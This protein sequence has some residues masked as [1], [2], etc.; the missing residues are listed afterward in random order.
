MLANFFGKSKPVNF[1][2][3]IVLF[4]VYNF[5]DVFVIN[6]SSFELKS[7]VNNLILF[8]G[9]L[10]M[11]FLYVFIITK[12]KLTFD[13]T[14]SFLLIVIGVGCLPI[15]KTN[16]FVVGEYIVLLLLFRRIYS[17]RTQKSIYQKLFDSGLWLGILFLLSPINIL[18]VVLIYC[19]ISL[20]T[21]PTVRTVFIPVLGFVSPLILFFTYHFVNDTAE[22]FYRIFDINVDIS[23]TFYNLLTYKLQLGV[24]GILTLISVLLKSSDIFSVSNTFKKSWGLLI[25][26]FFIAVFYILLIENKSGFELFSLLIPS[27][28]IIANWVQ[29]VKKKFLIDVVLIVLLILPFLIKLIV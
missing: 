11:F 3:I 17:L 25:I 23:Y 14:Y 15:F 5:L 26:H 8:P 29:S 24:F 22:V 9:F 13:N 1:V 12:N 20:Y 27:T 7:I 21:E 2:F 19:A 6:S 4:L 28:I 18:Y 10:F 16:Y